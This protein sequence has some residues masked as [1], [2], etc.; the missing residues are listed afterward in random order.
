MVK[1]VLVVEDN[2][3]SANLIEKI[4][5]SIDSSIVV[6]MA[7]NSETAYKYA[8]EKEIDVFIVDIILNTKVQGDTSGIKFANEMRTV[9]KY[10]FTPMIFMTS[11]EDPQMYA[12]RDL[13]CYGYLEKPFDVDKAEAL[14]RDALKYEKSVIEDETIYFKKEKIIYPHKISDIIFTCNKN[15]TMVIHHKNGTTL[16]IPYKT[17]SQLL[18]EVRSDF[19]IQCNRNTLVNKRYIKTVDLVNRYITL[20]NQERVEIGGTYLKKVERELK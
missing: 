5:T 7:E 4:I 9:Q 13:H 1:N 20:T 3:R 19:L 14:I 18:N 8:M 15:H 11:L 17:C 10:L 16:S 6:Y 12:Y 2:K